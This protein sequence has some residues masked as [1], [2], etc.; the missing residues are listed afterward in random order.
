MTVTPPEGRGAPP[1]LDGL[2][3]PRTRRQWASLYLSS[4]LQARRNPAF[5][6]VER[7]CLFIGYSRSGHTLV[8]TLLN[9]HP[10]VVVAHELD[11]VRYVRHGFGR[12]QLFSLLLMRDQQF[13]SN[14]R[15]WSGYHYEVPDQYQGQFD[16]LR[17]IGDKR[18]RS[19]VLQIAQR[20]QLLDRF[21]RVVKAPLRV[22]HVT[23]N[24]FDNIATESRR[25]KMSP[26]QGIEWYEQIC[27]AVDVV[28]PLLDPEEL[29]DVRY[30]N[31]AG[32]ARSGL[33]A[34][35][36]FLGVDADPSY[37]EACAAIVWPNTKPTRDAV[38][39]TAAE[40][41]AVE[42]LIERY[43]ALSSYTFTE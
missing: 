38:A 9:A 18:A 37:L 33:A 3:D 36:G 43:D 16:R 32:H 7:F 17:V 40:R 14:G 41:G 8:A 4:A 21:R 39:W 5:G 19:T 22:I 28:R 24:P 10:E 20:P 27:K 31:F 42:R 35:C 15:T 13:G 29:V 26:T 6:D 23:R 30:E 11:A 2:P 1:A 25:Q 12:T 34:L